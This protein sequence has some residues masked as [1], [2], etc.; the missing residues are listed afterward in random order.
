MEVFQRE[1]ERTVDHLYESEAQKAHPSLVKTVASSQELRRPS[2]DGSINSGTESEKDDSPSRAPPKQSGDGSN[3]GDEDDK[4]SEI[5]IEEWE[6]P[7]EYARRVMTK[8]KCK[9]KRQTKPQE[10]TVAETPEE[11]DKTD[12]RGS[13]GSRTPFWLEEIVATYEDDDM[14]QNPSTKNAVDRNNTKGQASA[15]GSSRPISPK[16]VPGSS[17]QGDI[18]NSSDK[19]SSTE[20]NKSR[21]ASSRQEIREGKHPEKSIDLGRVIVEQYSPPLGRNHSIRRKPVGSSAGPSKPSGTSGMASSSRTT[22]RDPGGLEIIP[23]ENPHH[24]GF[25]Y[26]DLARKLER[27]MNGLEFPLSAQSTNGGESQPHHPDQSF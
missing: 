11:S 20:R 7:D 27:G 19:S 25:P 5:L 23:D 22:H 16:A 21:D 8:E 14:R 1:Y 3:D 12:P 9:E 10:P 17:K 18:S 15:S 6:D 26:E 13:D 4:K 24:E 2:S